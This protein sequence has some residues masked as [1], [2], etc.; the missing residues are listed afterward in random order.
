[1]TLEQ[2]LVITYVAGLLNVLPC[3]N[4]SYRTQWVPE[5]SLPAHLSL[6]WKA[7]WY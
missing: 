4:S 3:R 2:S 6:S 5:M 7:H 1:M